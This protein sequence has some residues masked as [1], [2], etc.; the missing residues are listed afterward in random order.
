[1]IESRSW[2]LRLVW[3][4]YLATPL[5]WGADLLWRVDF[6][7]AWLVEP[8]YRSIYYLF[9]ITVAVM[10]YLRCRWL[11][12]LGVLES[13]VNLLL[14]LASVMLP[15]YH[16]PGMGGDGGGQLVF[17]SAQGLLTFML[18]AAVWLTAFHSAQQSLRD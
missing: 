8:G 7:V 11:A 17:T 13:S 18:S 10:G 2:P 16:L 15:I 4:Y 5:F 6:R 12:L 1:M 9:C 3:F 14:L